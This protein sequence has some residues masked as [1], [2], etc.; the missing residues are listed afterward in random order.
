MPWAL[1]SDWTDADQVNQFLEAYHERTDFSQTFAAS[2]NGVTVGDDVQTHVWVASLQTNLD[3]EVSNANWVKPTQSFSG[4]TSKSQIERVDFAYVSANAWGGNSAWTRKYPREFANSGSSAYADGSAFANGHNARNLATGLVY[5]RAAGA[6]VLAAEPAAPDV[7]TTTGYMQAGDYFGDWIFNE[8][9]DV[10]NLLV[11]QLAPTCDIVNGSISQYDGS[12]NVSGSQTSWALA[13]AAA[14]ADFQLRGTTS[15]I[16]AYTSGS[17]NSPPGAV[18]NAKAASYT[19]PVRVGFGFPKSCGVDVFVK[20]EKPTTIITTVSQSDTTFDSNGQGLT[21]GVYGTALTTT[22]GGSYGT[23]TT[24]NI[25]YGAAA[26]P[27]W[28]A[29]PPTPGSVAAGYYVA[30]STVMFAVLKYNVMGGLE[31][32]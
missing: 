16:L 10:L 22:A 30:G 26:V 20:A 23:L 17:A 6:W 4:Y 8:L 24:I 3:F 18:Y 21:E 11:W 27:N 2:G 32:Q 31:Y 12:T 19:G 9:H 28:C 25:P 13:Q 29:A 1:S 7:V 14:A 15:I 5:T